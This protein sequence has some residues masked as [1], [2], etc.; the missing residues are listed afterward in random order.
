MNPVKLTPLR[1]TITLA[2][3]LGTMGQLSACWTGEVR[4]APFPARSG[5]VEPG[6][7]RGPFDGL[8]LDEG[9][10]R[11]VP[12]AQV[13]AVWHFVSQ[14]DGMQ[15]PAGAKEWLGTTDVGG[16]YHVP[17]LTDFNGRRLSTVKI[18]I[19][20]RGYVAYRSDRR[21]DD[22]GPR[23]DFAQHDNS[24]HLT[25]WSSDIS[26]VRHLRYVG[27]GATMT[28]L[29]RWELPEAAAELSGTTATPTTAGLGPLVAHR[30][31]GEGPVLPAGRLLTPADVLEVTGWSGEFVVTDLGDEAPS[32]AYNSVHLGAKNA[33]QEYDVALRMWRGASPEE[34]GEVFDKLMAELPNTKETD[35]LGDRSLRAIDGDVLALAYLA[36]DAHVVVLVQCGTGQCKSG[37]VLLTIARRTK[38]HLDQ[39]ISEGGLK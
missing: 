3:A 34:A 10:G 18:I 11:P 20:K 39:I 15:A 36:K 38:E 1:A 23:L 33:E 2:V 13:Y 14:D 8:V 4:S 7:L 6:D 9:N 31:A 27:G 24:V 29:T 21:F 19:F 25:R 32:A 26:H 16:R 5:S 12:G 30:G 17:R 28:E 22:F 37:E 35:E